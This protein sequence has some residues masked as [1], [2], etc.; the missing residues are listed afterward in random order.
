MEM[1]NDDAI[2]IPVRPVCQGTSLGIFG[3]G[4]GVP[5]CEDNCIPDLISIGRIV[6][7]ASPYLQAAYQDFQEVRSIIRKM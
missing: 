4:R 7:K 6:G 3:S 1:D 2:R 5:N